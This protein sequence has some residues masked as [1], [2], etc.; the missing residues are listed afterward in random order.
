MAGFE[1]IAREDQLPPV[2][3][4][5]ETIAR[6]FKRLW[7][8]GL[9]ADRAAVATD[10][11]AFA[12]RIGGAI[13]VGAFEDKSRR[14]LGAYKP[15]DAVTAK[16]VLDAC[17]LAVRDLCSPKPIFELARVEKDGGFV[18]V[19]NVWPFPGQAVGVLTGK[20]SEGAYK[21][22][23]RT[24]TQCTYLKPEQLPM[25]MI[26]Q[27]RRVVAQLYAI[28]KDATVVIRSRAGNSV[29]KL[30]EVDE[31]RNVV[32]LSGQHQ[33]RNGIF[34]FGLDAINSVWCNEQGAWQVD[35]GNLLDR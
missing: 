7:E 9:P 11:A 24:G 8:G 26:P 33:G 12:N 23:F 18:V 29:L 19:I 22:P 30:V 3:T 5:M 27:L 4:A 6:D 31:I 34:H 35:Q 20:E 15:F 25:L 13:I 28:P 32:R 17:D 1:T 14:V 2:G 16:G 21:F 10:V